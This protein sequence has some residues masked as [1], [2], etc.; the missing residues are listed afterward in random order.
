[1]IKGVVWCLALLL[2]SVFVYGSVGCEYYNSTVVRCENEGSIAP[3]TYLDESSGFFQYANTDIDRLDDVTYSYGMARKIL[4][5]IVYYGLT[6]LDADTYFVSDNSTFWS[7]STERTIDLP[8]RTVEIQKV[9]YQERYDDDINIFFSVKP[10]KNTAGE[11]YLA[12][13]LHD[14]DVGQDGVADQVVISDGENITEFWGNPGSTQFYYNVIRLV[15][16]GEYSYRLDFDDPVLVIVNPVGLNGD[17][18]ILS[19]IGYLDQYTTYDFQYR[20]IDAGCTI[21]C[22][23]G[24]YMYVE[25]NTSGYDVYVD[26]AEVTRQTY[27]KPAK[28]GTCSI[29]S[30][31]MN[32]CASQDE[33][34][35]EFI[36]NEVTDLPVRCSG[37]VQCRLVIG[38]VWSY[39]ARPVLG[40]STQ[41][42]GELNYRCSIG[43]VGYCYGP[44][45][46]GS[47][48]TVGEVYRNV[49]LLTPADGTLINDSHV[50]EVFGCGYEWA[51]GVV[52]AD[53]TSI[54][55]W[56]QTTPIY[57][58]YDELNV[59]QNISLDTSISWTC[60]TCFAHSCYQAWN[61]NWTVTYFTYTPIIEELQGLS[62]EKKILIIQSEQECTLLCKIRNAFAKWRK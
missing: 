60:E 21:S 11:H 32:Q 58:Q 24:S 27:C 23:V 25:S 56:N 30:C 47:I 26:Q 51:N 9:M 34:T 44:H 33:V 38:A 55:F 29:S 50:W 43:D 13:A 53:N 57:T 17:F 19:Y 1:M 18:Y 2:G 28:V 4:N 49:T 31:Y 61:G 42:N 46:D 59:S 7:A 52:D 5:T 41:H 54:W 10:N 14:I 62:T 22:S 3:V 48:Y 36:T 40:A 16:A 45:D 20:W 6:G 37:A 8:R 15:I 35:W 39:I 12:S